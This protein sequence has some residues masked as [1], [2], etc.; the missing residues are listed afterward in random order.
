MSF[1]VSFSK[2]LD[3][4]DSNDIGLYDVPSFGS[5]LGFGIGMIFAS[6]Q[7][8]GRLFYCIARL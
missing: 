3:I 1:S 6:F 4:E 2:V 8:C 5:L 7:I